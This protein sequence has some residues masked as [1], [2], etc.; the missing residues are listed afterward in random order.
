M[1]LWLIPDSWWWSEGARFC[2]SAARLHHSSCIIMP[3]PISSQLSVSE[4][5]ILENLIKTSHKKRHRTMQRCSLL[6]S[7]YSSPAILIRPLFNNEFWFITPRRACRSHSSS[8]L[9]LLTVSIF[10]SC[11]C[12]WCRSV[13]RCQWGAL[14]SVHGT[15]QRARQRA[16]VAA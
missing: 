16:F 9:L 6:E 11:C 10:L 13:G 8:L 15:D 5:R 4:W 3:S 1:S 12:C 14:A 2:R 7:I